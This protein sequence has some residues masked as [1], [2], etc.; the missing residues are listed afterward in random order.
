MKLKTEQYKGYPI[1]FIERIMGSTKLVVG[2]FPSKITGRMLGVQG[3]SKDM[4][5]TK[6]K[7]MIDKE[8]KIKEIK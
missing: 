2:E 6:C 8:L 3:T 1:K 7:I 5:L 4:V